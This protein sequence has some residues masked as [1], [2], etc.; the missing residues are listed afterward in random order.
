VRSD[1]DSGIGPHPEPAVAEG[2]QRVQSLAVHRD[3]GCYQSLPLV[4]CL[5]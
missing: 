1:D 3:D 2:V 4:V 5:K